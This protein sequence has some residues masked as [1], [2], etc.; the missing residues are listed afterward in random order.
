MPTRWT[1]EVFHPEPIL[2]WRFTSRPWRPTGA[3]SSRL[4][5]CTEPRARARQQLPPHVVQVEH[6]NRLSS[7]GAARLGEACLDLL[8]RGPVRAALASRC[9]A[10]SELETDVRRAAGRE[11]D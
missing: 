8:G 3:R 1:W 4:P 11:L 7:S 10:G 6:R 9:T 2:G 5:G